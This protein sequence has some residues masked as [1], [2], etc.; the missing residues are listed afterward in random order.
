MGKTIK[1]P[2]NV[3]SK[4]LMKLTSEFVDIDA[5]PVSDE[6][7]LDFSGL[8]YVSASAVAL[9]DNLIGYLENKDVKIGVTGIE[10]KAK[11]CPIAFLRDAGF[12]EKYLDEPNDIYKIKKSKFIYPIKSLDSSNYEEWTV[13][14][15]YWIAGIIG[16]NK[17][18]IST[19]TVA[20]KEILNN[21]NDHANITTCG[22]FA[23]FIEE[24]KKF[25]I[26]IS[27]IGVGIP[28][29][30]KRF[31]KDD[32]SDLETLRWAVKEG[33]STKSTPRNRGVGLNYLINNI[34]KNIDGKVEIY[35]NKASI[36]C[37]NNENGI[38]LDGSDNKLMHPGTLILIK[39][40]EE[41]LLS[42]LDNEEEFSW[43][44]L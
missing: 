37:K 1:I 13:M 38:Y 11:M 39:L 36:V 28:Y 20:V 25:H 8:K 43:E 33:N 2:Q 6:F 19:L 21:V 42:N 17:N 30:V 44:E 18:Q 15:S 9:L 12:F 26:S 34:V 22:I 24:E 40:N 3:E 10:F 16:V 31:L 29:N 7:I 27:D 23:Q 4:E 32:I 41:K 14:F 5:N 35:S